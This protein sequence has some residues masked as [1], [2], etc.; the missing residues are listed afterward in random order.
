MNIVQH[1]NQAKATRRPL[2]EPL[3]IPGEASGQRAMCSPDSET[4]RWNFKGGGVGP[5]LALD[6]EDAITGCYSEIFSSAGPVVKQSSSKP[7]LTPPAVYQQPNQAKATRRPLTEPLEI[8]GETSGQR[9]MCSPDSETIRWN[10][11]GGGTGPTLAFDD[12]DAITRCCIGIFSSAGPV[13]KPSSPVGA[14][15][16]T[17]FIYY[18]CQ[19]S[20]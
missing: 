18:S 8:P 16:F 17:C 11:K 4:I 9:A 15:P 2:T 12:E 13:V 7:L 10:F 3:E 20:S 6:D 19:H 5:T 1:P 14:L